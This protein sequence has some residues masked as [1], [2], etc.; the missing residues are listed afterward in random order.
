MCRNLEER[1]TRAYLKMRDN[2]S[3]VYVVSAGC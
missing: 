3:E 2:V 1:K